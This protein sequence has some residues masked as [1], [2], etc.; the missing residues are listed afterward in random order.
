MQ[1]DV[2]RKHKHEKWHTISTN[3]EGDCRLVPSEGSP[4]QALMLDDRNS[5]Q[6]QN[7]FRF[8]V[9]LPCKQ[10][11]GNDNEKNTNAVRTRHATMSS[12]TPND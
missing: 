7:V 10:T 5:H 6:W 11:H 2:Q 4:G 3:D 12:T 9:V 1:L 8:P